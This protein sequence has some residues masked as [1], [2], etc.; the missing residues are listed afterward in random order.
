MAASPASVRYVSSGPCVFSP[1]GRGVSPAAW[2]RVVRPP[3]WCRSE[4][5]PAA[6][7]VRRLLAVH[8]VLAGAGARGVEVLNEPVVSRRL[9]AVCVHVQR[10]PEVCVEKT[11]LENWFPPLS[12]PFSPVIHSLCFPHLKTFLRLFFF[13]SFR[14]YPRRLPPFPSCLLFPFFFS[15]VIPATAIFSSLKT[16]FSFF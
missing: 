9:R 1:R 8:A 3:G 12:A 11:A 5:R 13:F 4:S 7:A 6:M 10:R 15:P 2:R 14:L 16:P